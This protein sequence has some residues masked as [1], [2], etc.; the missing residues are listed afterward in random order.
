[1]K[2]YVTF[3]VESNWYLL[4]IEDYNDFQ[5]NLNHTIY[6]VLI[7]FQSSDLIRE[8][9]SRYPKRKTLPTIIDLESFDKQMSQRGKENP[10]IKKKTWKILTR[11]H[12]HNLIDSDF[13]LR[14]S[15]IKIFLEKTAEWY[16]ILRENNDETLRFK[17]VE[18][19]INKIIYNRQKLGINI[20][21][22]SAEKKCAEIEKEI[23]SIKNELQL[24]HNIFTPDEVETQKRYLTQKKYNIIQSYLYSFKIRRKND[25][26]CNLFY[27]LLRNQQDLDSMLYI[28][29]H[30]GGKK[31]CYPKYVG[32]GS[33]TSRIILQQPSLQNLRKKNRDIIT[34]DVGK[35]LLYI[36]YTQF[37]AGILASLSVDKSLIKLYDSDIYMDFAN[38]VLKNT[39]RQE[40]KIYFYRYMYGDKTLKT[41]VQNYFN[42]FAGLNKFKESVEKEIIEESKIGTSE[43]NFRLILD[44]SIYH[45]ALSHK[46][47]AT[48]SL[49][50]KLALIE[51]A[52]KVPEADFLIPMH[53]GAVY[54]IDEFNYS[55]SKDKIEKI[56]KASYKKLCP[57]IEPRVHSKETFD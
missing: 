29:A 41:S 20:D 28:L 49:I 38:K 19:E 37:E 42:K 55:R 54:Q 1:M 52:K 31:K 57:N 14:Q 34:V 3:Y 47:Q 16:K 26:V 36:D 51:V 35:K 45:W 46:I 5:E 8:L 33:I 50:F 15:S 24:S 27:E 2:K 13:S 43:G 48:A 18:L 23:Y 56:F 9:S 53:D 12:E 6:D 10:D 11:L 30:W 4:N 7:T 25:P 39:D 17:N 40:A 32:F 21:V 22:I 44:E